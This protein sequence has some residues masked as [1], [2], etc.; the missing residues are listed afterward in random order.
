MEILTSMTFWIVIVVIIVLL[1]IVGYVAE[2]TILAGKKQEK[3]KNEKKEEKEALS[4]WTEDAPA[5][6]DRQEKVYN[7]ADQSWLDMPDVTSATETLE[8]K[9]DAQEPKKEIIPEVSVTPM[10]ESIGTA[11]MPS[12]PQENSSLPTDT[13]VS[14]ENNKPE[15]VASSIK[16]VSTLSGPVKND[17]SPNATVQ[18]KTP[19]SPGQQANTVKPQDKGHETETL[20][21]WTN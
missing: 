4:A 14:K 13:P 19:I 12:A 18:E 11:P 17:P 20:D 1:A 15:M 8:P 16:E 5:M 3:E 7:T 9:A 2:G 6:D 10:S 21:I